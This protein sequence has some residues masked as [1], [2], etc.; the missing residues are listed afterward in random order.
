LYTQQVR[1]VNKCMD[2]LAA[3]ITVEPA[4]SNLMDNIRQL[5]G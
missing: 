3:P 1:M 2:G 5:S 4:I